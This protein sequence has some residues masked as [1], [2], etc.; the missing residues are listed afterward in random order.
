MTRNQSRKL[1][2]D[3]PDYWTWLR[4][5]GM[6][7]DEVE[8]N[9]DLDEWG[10]Q[11]YDIMFGFKSPEDFDLDGEDEDL[12]E[13]WETTDGDVV[14]R[15]DV[16][17]YQ[18]P[19]LSRADIRKAEEYGLED[20]TQWFSD[21]N[22]DRDTFLRGE[23]EDLESY[24]INYIGDYQLVDGYLF[25]DEGVSC[26][27][28]E[29]VAMRPSKKLKESAPVKEAYDP[30]TLKDYIVKYQD[31]ADDMAEIWEDVY[32][33]TFDEDLANDVI[34]G[35]EEIRDGADFN[36]WNDEWME[37]LKESAENLDGFEEVGTLYD[38][39]GKIHYILR[40]VG[41]DGTNIHGF[42][43]AAPQGS[44]YGPD[45]S[46]AFD[47]TYKQAT[48]ED[49]LIS[50]ALTEDFDRERYNELVAHRKN[51]IAAYNETN[52]LTPEDTVKALV[53]KDGYDLAMIEIAEAVNASG[54]WDR[55]LY[56]ETREW[57]KNVAGAASHEELENNKLFDF[58]SWIHSSHLN[59]IAQAAM[60]FKS[61]PKDESLTEGAEG[62]R[63]PG[64]EYV[65]YDYTDEDGPNPIVAIRSTAVE[66]EYTA[67][68][69]MNNDYITNSRPHPKYKDRYLTFEKVPKGKF[70]VGDDF[71][72]PFD[73][74]YNKVE[75]L[76]EEL[77]DEEIFDILGIEQENRTN[78]KHLLSQFRKLR[79]KYGTDSIWLKGDVG[80]AVKGKVIGRSNDLA[81][82][83]SLTESVNYKYVVSVNDKSGKGVAT[84]RGKIKAFT[85]RDAEGKVR[86]ILTIDGG[87]KSSDIKKITI[88][89]DT[90]DE[91]LK[92]GA[93]GDIYTFSRKCQLDPDLPD[94]GGY[95][96]TLEDKEHGI[97]FN[98]YWYKRS[99]YAASNA[100]Y[101]DLK[102]DDPKIRELLFDALSNFEASPNC[103]TELKKDIDSCLP[104]GSK[105]KYGPTETVQNPTIVRYSR[106][107]YRYEYPN[108]HYTEKKDESL[109]EDAKEPQ[110]LTW[111]EIWDLVRGCKDCHTKLDQLEMIA[112]LLY[113][114]GYKNI[115]FDTPEDALAYAME[116]QEAMFG[117]YD[118]TVD[119]YND[120]LQT[121]RYMRKPSN[122]SLKEDLPADCIPE[123]NEQTA[124]WKWLDEDPL[125]GWEFFHFPNANP[126]EYPYM[127]PY[128]IRTGSDD[129]GHSVYIALSPRTTWSEAW[130][131][132]R[133]MVKEEAAKRAATGTRNG[134]APSASR[135]AAA[136]GEKF[137]AIIA[138]CQPT[139]T[140]Y[141]TFDF[142]V[143]SEEINLHCNGTEE[144]ENLDGDLEDLDLE[145]IDKME[146]WVEKIDE[147]LPELDASGGLGSD[148][149]SGMS[150]G[151]EKGPLTY[152]G[153]T[154]TIYLE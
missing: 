56:P 46:K 148:W 57:A 124:Y 22:P 78:S 44:D 8:D 98:I 52:E 103:F 47:I 39:K 133:R 31:S 85:K 62:K 3:I 123:P 135:T 30:Q 20:V 43:K 116:M 114:R 72:G 144:I 139:D 105:V 24:G 32:N 61:E 37:C 23:L 54:D 7:P 74:D 92:E 75:A 87:Y 26:R 60:K 113:G 94:S 9:P 70:K 12:G 66:A 107:G 152:D 86:E 109:K 154:Y 153:F 45:F 129:K 58:S 126:N 21:W 150:L 95:K 82:V 13:E 151:G 16:V 49:P 42:W 101:L 5:Q 134:E 10:R 40:K 38:Q 137:G 81:V 97:S 132:W 96:V 18:F 118:P 136:K 141:Y 63:E 25:D 4:L 122:E 99:G 50:P 28:V 71:Y 140:E 76:K 2:E 51:V 111:R 65:I 14:G 67:M 69:W 147:L 17:I 145:A 100:D 90:T 108:P 115:T 83:E 55:R 120:I 93:E 59:Q 106:S 142:D 121:L 149:F 127:Y 48:G 19:H 15:N 130:V 84:I 138:Q 29:G 125:T 80:S 89:E 41:L 110:G 91:S 1:N 77:S 88:A 131:E 79:K 53:D 6:D 68:R 35:L 102:C 104:A 34:S 33:E 146:G 27:F 112:R 117:W 64:Y 119:E 11:Q 143:D 36:C 73:A 128:M